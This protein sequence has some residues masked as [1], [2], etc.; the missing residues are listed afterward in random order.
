MAATAACAGM[1]EVVIAFGRS[2]NSYSINEFATLVAP[3]PTL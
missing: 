1:A 3:C 2:L